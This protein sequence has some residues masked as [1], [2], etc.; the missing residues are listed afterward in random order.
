MKRLLFFISRL[1]LNNEVGRN[2]NHNK[3]W[4][5]KVKQIIVA[6]FIVGSALISPETGKANISMPCSSVLEPVNT[7]YV[8]SKGVALVYKV[9]LTSS[10]ISCK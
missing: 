7:D 8:N 10:I 9:V 6:L 5:D 4:R 2:N 3:M 1:I